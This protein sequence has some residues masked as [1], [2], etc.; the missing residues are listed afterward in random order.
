MAY[1]SPESGGQLL[2]LD[3][4]DLPVSGVVERYPAGHQVP[5][6]NHPYG[7]L[8]Y[9]TEGLLL[10]Q[11]SSGQWLVPPTTAVWLR[12][13]VQHCLTATTAVSA[14]GIFIREDLS[15]QLPERD[16]VLH[17]TPLVRELVAA[18]AV[19]QAAAAQRRSRLL[20]ELLLEELKALAP[21]PLHLPWPEDALM[22]QICEALVQEPARAVNADAIASQHALTTKTLHRR[23]LKSTGMNLGK[24]RQQMRL[25]ASIQLLLQ[26]MTI[27]SV[28][29][30]S[31]YESHSA[32]TVAFKKNFGCPPSEFVL[33]AQGGTFG[34]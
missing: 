7:H 19:Q 8:I 32:Y 12:P 31:G 28:A 6:H 22:R 17:V 15:V 1:A 16:C 14:C 20:G 34:D 30:E 29:L 18:L 2:K 23:F 33:I 5:A 26:G 9:A 11:A 13:N 4:A 21:L 25:M 10:V 3:G 24:W 27:T